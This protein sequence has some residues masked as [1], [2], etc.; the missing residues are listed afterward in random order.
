MPGGGGDAGEPLPDDVRRVLGGV[1]QH[2]AGHPRRCGSCGWSM[3]ARLRDLGTM[4]SAR[5]AHAALAR[6]G[7]AVWLGFLGAVVQALFEAVLPC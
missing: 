1:E 6:V 4:G 2:T 3:S 7:K 5:F